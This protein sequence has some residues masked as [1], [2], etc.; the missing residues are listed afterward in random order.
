MA[1]ADC[2][3]LAQLDTARGTEECQF[4]SKSGL[5]RVLLG[6]LPM[7]LPRL[8]HSRRALLLVAFSSLWTACGKTSGAGD[9]DSSAAGGDGGT[10]SSQQSGGSGG[11]GGVGGTSF[12]GDGPVST[13]DT[14]TTNSATTDSITTGSITTAGG[15]GGSGGEP[16]CGRTEQ[17]LEGCY[18]VYASS[19]GGGGGA[20]PIDPCW[21]DD[22]PENCE[23]TF[24]G[25]VSDVGP[26]Y[27]DNCG[28]PMFDGLSNL[29]E[30]GRQWLRLHSGQLKMDIILG[31]PEGA[32]D[33][34]PGDTVSVNLLRAS[35]HDEFMWGSR[36]TL[37]KGGE[38]LAVL[39]DNLP[40][41]EPTA[42]GAL[43]LQRGAEV[44]ER[45][46]DVFTCSYIAH[47]LDVQL[48]DEGLGVPPDSTA[49]FGPYEI[50]TEEN[51]HMRDGGGC[52]SGDVSD[53]VIARVKP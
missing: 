52:D 46:E 25:Q 42:F 40:I 4:C 49:R 19:G 16:A 1:T 13:G 50:L 38:L 32:I 51:F 41:D 39:N 43:T 37:T 8:A 45:P 33:I 9:T 6:S 5:E 20:P 15:V 22:A 7:T 23:A 30:E 36:L 44:C 31:R 27:E 11:S 21:D 2:S 3:R 18:G 24:E 26:G 53:F 17:R 14:V 10:G 29:S 48:D 34:E 47:D 35:Y 12:G 28:I